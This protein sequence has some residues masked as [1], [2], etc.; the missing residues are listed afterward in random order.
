[1]LALAISDRDL[2]WLGYLS[3]RCD[4]A[5]AELAESL[6]LYPDRDEEVPECL[7]VRAR[8]HVLR[9][10]LAVLGNEVKAHKATA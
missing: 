9:K 2:L 3:L 7:M 10:A 8:V 1:M 4:L 5:E 6:I